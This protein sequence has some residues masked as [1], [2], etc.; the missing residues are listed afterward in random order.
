MCELSAHN[1]NMMTGLNEYNSNQTSVQSLKDLYLL[2]SLESLK[3]SIV[4]IPTDSLFLNWFNCRHTFFMRFF[5]GI[6]VFTKNL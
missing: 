4:F 1:E 3:G 5:I 6:D 2:S